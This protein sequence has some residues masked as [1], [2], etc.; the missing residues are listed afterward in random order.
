C[1]EQGNPIH[2][3]AVPPPRDDPEPNDWS[4]FESSAHFELADFLYKENQMLAGNI[5]KLLKIWGQHAAST[6]G[7][8]PFQNHKDLY[9]TIDSI[10]VGDVPWQSFNLSYSRSRPN[11]EGVD[12]PAWMDD[13]HAVWFCDPH[14]LICNLLS[15]TDFDGKFDYTPFQEYDDKGSH[16]YQDFMS[17]NWA[18]RQAANTLGAMFVPIILGSDKTTVS[19]ATGLNEYWPIYLSIGN[20]RNNVRRAHR[21][22]LVLMGFLPIAKTISGMLKSLHPAFTTPEVARCP[23]GHFRR[24]IY[25]AGPYIADY[26]EQCMLSCLV[27][28]WCPKCMAPSNNLEQD[29]ITRTQKLAEELSE[30]HELGELWARFGIV[31]DI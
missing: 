7:E 24:A 22:G 29:S 3:N 15:N 21:D 5:D 17:G 1:D 20:I 9:E 31:G 30:F 25:G 11:L 4:P 26:P 14:E 16:R 19:V 6:G 2:H 28:G 23:D 10:P 13:T 12:D 18:W 8:A 27:Q